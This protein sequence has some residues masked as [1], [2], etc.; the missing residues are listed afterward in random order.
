MILAAN[1]PTHP[2]T[3][4]I[5]RRLLFEHG[6]SHATG[7]A[8]ALGFMAVVAACTSL[9]AW[10]M[11]DL[12]N[13]AFVDRDRSAMLYFPALVSALFIVKG[14]FSYFQEITVTRIGGRIVSEVQQRLY[15]HLL[16]MDVGFF[17]RRSSS[18]LITRITGGA[19]AARDMINL[20]A[21]SL[22]RDLLTILG[23]CG[24]MVAQDPVLFA[25][26]L[27]TA[28]FAAMGL[29]KLAAAAKQAANMETGASGDVL[30]L[31]R[32][33]SQGIRMLKSF[34]LEGILKDRMTAATAAVEQQ[35]NALARVKAAVAPL[36]E[37]LSG[38]AI[39]AVILYATLRSQND[40][41]MIGRFFS[42][43]T[44]LLLAGEPIRRL[45][46]LH[47][48]LAAAGERVRM[49]YEILDL[50]PAE[51]HTK[52]E[53]ALVVREGA[54]A[55]NDVCFAYSRDKPVLKGITI[56]IPAGK[57]TAF[58]GPSGGGK[59][60]VLGLIQ[61]FYE[62]SSG[63]ISID[64]TPIASVS[65]ESLR[66]QVSYLD[67]DAFLFEGTIEDNIVGSSPKRDEIRILEAAQSA[68]ADAFIRDLPHGYKT[69]IRELG[70]NFSGGQR[71][72]I[73]IARAFYKNAPILLLDEPTSA[74]DSESER[75]IQAS[76]LKLARSRTTLIVAHRLSTIIGADVIHVV[77][78]GNVVE[79]GGHA[80]L[81]A[82]GGRYARL[83][84]S[85]PH[86]QGHESAA[87]G[88]HPA[89]KLA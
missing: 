83:Y 80:D 89:S 63:T 76:L 68:D 77:E 37:V 24:V 62:P 14:I 50:P 52:D 2:T 30:G 43:I 33:T 29:K 48:D 12:V 47:I 84:Q 35:R 36:S 25:I 9:S 15:D 11:K 28:P 22:G 72:R 79:S 31:T 42:F 20:T 21:V 18:D 16:Q 60:T 19:Q 17:H 6:R 40:P 32:E 27:T 67:Q 1:A 38:I 78:R 70:A 53:P 57:I 85:K 26:V 81:I 49:L 51:P 59:T 71:Q 5:L 8:I 13:T 4:S 10:I 65:R 61:R 55:L 41:E 34:Q 64:G 44:A 39:G 66:R 58:V 54:I 88:A 82:L 86:S 3:L 74:L 87:I 73:A 23:L 56:A 75:Q 69:K 46:R 7:Y 45:S